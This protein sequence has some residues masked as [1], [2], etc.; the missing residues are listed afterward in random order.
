M[1]HCRSNPSLVLAMDGHMCHGI[2][3]IRQ[4]AA[5]TETVKHKTTH[6][7]SAIASTSNLP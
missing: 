3:S 7:S 5:I 1:L 4:S 6:V 2:I